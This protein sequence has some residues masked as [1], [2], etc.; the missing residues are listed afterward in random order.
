MRIR[1]AIAFVVLAAA[2]LA[3]PA[4]A[5]PDTVRIPIVKPIP[6]RIPAAP[7]VFRHSTHGMYACYG[8]H[9]TLFPKHRLGFTHLD[10]AAGR[11]CA[12]CHDGGG[13]FAVSDAAC[14]HCHAPN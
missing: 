12:A 10:M 2:G 6:G 13:A 8:C 3:A 7:A 9:P 14:E 5:M 11:Y 1:I 4:V